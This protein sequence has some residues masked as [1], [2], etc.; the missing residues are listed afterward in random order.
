MFLEMVVDGGGG[1]D[2]FVI[3]INTNDGMVAA[4]SITAVHLTT[5]RV[6]KSK[7]AG[8]VARVARAATSQEHKKVLCN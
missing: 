7:G 4:A 5:G 1:D 6:H 8:A 2:V 3:A